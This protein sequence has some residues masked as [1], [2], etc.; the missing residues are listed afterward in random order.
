MRYYKHKIN[1][2]DC[3]GVCAPIQTVNNTIGIGNPTPPQMAATT[4]AEMTDPRC[5]GSGD[6][7]GSSSEP[8][9]RKKPKFKRKKKV[10]EGFENTFDSSLVDY[11]DDFKES[12]KQYKINL[13]K[14]FIHKHIKTLPNNIPIE[15]IYYIDNDYNVHF[16]NSNINDI[17]INCPEAYS[18]QKRTFT[19]NRIEQL[20]IN[21]VECNCSI[22]ANFLGLK[23]LKG[24]PKKVNGAFVVNHN[25]LKS[26]EYGPE[27]VNQLYSVEHNN[28]D[29][30][31]GAPKIINHTDS[32][33]KNNPVLRLTSNPRLKSNEGLPNDRN[34]T[35]EYPLGYY[36]ANKDSNEYPRNY[37]TN[38]E[39]EKIKN[40]LNSYYKSFRVNKDQTYINIDYFIYIIKSDVF[41]NYFGLRWNKGNSSHPSEAGRGKH[42]DVYTLIKEFKKRK[43]RG[44]F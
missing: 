43:D 37:I 23:T 14:D 30:L 11:S 42:W 7:F 33:P 36:R 12:D 27:E 13:I 25:R 1:E 9:K 44:T 6:K 31:I 2:C 32:N 15:E 5:I 24:F 26:L 38:N 29:S 21:I 40:D 18:V 41:D 19:D 17:F 10:D 22:H 34:Y 39:I 35:I 20:P 8:K 4:G 16:T 28:L 3:G